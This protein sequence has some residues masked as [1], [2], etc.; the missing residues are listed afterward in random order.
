MSAKRTPW[1]PGDVKPVRRGWYERFYSQSP[2][3]IQRWF[4]N[5]RLWMY[6][7]F[8]GQFVTAVYQDRPWRGLTE[9]Q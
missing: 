1:Y 5:G 4:W 7:T 8:N 9:K 3:L 2:E 6:T